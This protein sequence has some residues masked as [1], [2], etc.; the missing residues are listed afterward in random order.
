[1]ISAALFCGVRFSIRHNHGIGIMP[2][3]PISA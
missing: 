3:M 1:L 2:V